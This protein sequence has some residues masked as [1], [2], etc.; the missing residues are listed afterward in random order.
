M[1]KHK[2]TPGPW[3]YDNG[4]LKSKRGSI[5]VLVIPKNVTNNES[6]REANA[7]L[8]AS[9][10]EL[11]EAL[12]TICDEVTDLTFDQLCMVKNAIRKARGT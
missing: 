2:P 9:A 7:N 8:I 3:T 12:E 5:A 4:V 1:G 10:P 6:E 11:L